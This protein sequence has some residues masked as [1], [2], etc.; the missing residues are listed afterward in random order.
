MPDG[1]TVPGKLIFKNTEGDFA[2]Q[3]D[4]SRRKRDIRTVALK[5]HI[6][7]AGMKYATGM[8]AEVLVPWSKLNGKDPAAKK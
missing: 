3:R 6:D 5:L 8:T 7:N 4:V 2:T 1:S